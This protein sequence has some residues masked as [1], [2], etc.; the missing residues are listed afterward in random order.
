M[1]SYKE[2]NIC[3]TGHVTVETVVGEKILKRQSNYKRTRKLSFIMF[4]VNADKLLGSRPAYEKN[5]LV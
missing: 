3:T 2:C 5:S 4:N 1:N